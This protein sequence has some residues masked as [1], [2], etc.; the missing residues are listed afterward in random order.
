M[1][2]TKTQFNRI[3][4][5]ITPSGIVSFDDFL[6]W[7]LIDRNHESDI[8]WKPVSKMCEICEHDWDVV[9]DT[10]NIQTAIDDI[11]ARLNPAGNITKRMLQPVFKKLNNHTTHSTSTFHEELKHLRKI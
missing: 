5:K 10:K 11:L 6:K 2:S 3:R 7:L 1:K 9:Y 4:F 8:H